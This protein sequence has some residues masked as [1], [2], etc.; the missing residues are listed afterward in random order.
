MFKTASFLVF[1]ALD[2]EMS[3]SFQRGRMP[4][5]DI[6]ASNGALTVCGTAIRLLLLGTPFHSNH[7]PVHATSRYNRPLLC[8][9]RERERRHFPLM[10]AA[11]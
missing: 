11:F 7:F 2:A 3:T 1:V 6:R 4:N 5:R 9:P 10:A 8:V